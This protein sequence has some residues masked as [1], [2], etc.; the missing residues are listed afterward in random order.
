MDNKE[1]SSRIV[2]LRSDTVTHPTEEMKQAML[3]AE[4]GDDVLG[5]DPT[6]KKLEE[7]AAR[8]FEKEAGL[9]VPSG[10]MG[11]LI[12]VLV[13]CEAR[14]SEAILGASSHIFVYEQGGLS[15]I[16]GVNPH[17]VPNQPDGTL[18]IED[19][20]H[21]IRPT[22][23]H[24]PTTKL[25]CLETTQNKCGGRVLKPEYI[26]AVGNLA[27]QHGLKLHIDGARIFNA[28][29]KLGVVPADYVRVADSVSVCLSKGLAAPVG[30]IILGTRDFIYKARR[31]RKAVGGGMRQS[32]VLAAA[33]LV[34]LTGMVDRLPEDHAN[35]QTL[36]QGITSIPGLSVDVASVETNIVFFDIDQQQTGLSG[37][38]LVAKLAQAGVRC[39]ASGNKIRMVTHYQVTSDDIQYTLQCLRQLVNQ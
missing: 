26:E 32:G 10:T 29:T 8:I 18:R 4:L 27:H 31:L 21:A 16:G 36:A 15:Q 24:F 5:D 12:S 37:P 39:F 30:S 13:H 11:N 34:A 33:G 7:T 1:N 9:F 19:I 35:A 22:D 20:L 38:E 25:V 2:D 6:V 3:V 17:T 28:I 14:G 23:D